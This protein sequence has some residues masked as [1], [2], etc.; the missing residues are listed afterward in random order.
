MRIIYNAAKLLGKTAD[1]RVYKEKYETQL[2]RVRKEYFTAGGRLCYDTVTAQVISLYFD[3]A[4]KKHRQKLA[5]ALNENVK[6]HNYTLST[7]FIGTTYLLFAL[8]DNG[9]KIGRAHV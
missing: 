8:A 3:I 9:Y 5:D 4:P 6:T 2:K 1:A 7:G